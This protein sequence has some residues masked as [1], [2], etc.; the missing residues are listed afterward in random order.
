ML[1]LISWI[2]MA[3]VAVLVVLLS[4]S[5]RDRITL[6]LDPLPYSFDLPVVAVILGAVAVGFI[7]GAFAAWA[8]GAK[9]R[10]LSRQRRYQAEQAERNA[11]RLQDRLNKLESQSN[12]MASQGAESPASLKRLS[13]PGSNAA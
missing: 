2:I 7:W 5:N 3:P 13:S 6:S 12:E 10:G 1:R 8:S 9:T 11:K 4:I